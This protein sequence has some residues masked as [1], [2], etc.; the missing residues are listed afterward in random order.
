MNKLIESEFK[1]WRCFSDFYR[2]ILFERDSFSCPIC[3]SS[4]KFDFY[5][6]LDMD[7]VGRAKIF[8]NNSGCELNKLNLRVEAISK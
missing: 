8:C 7:K 3:S 4:I 6:G 2:N 1:T 5:L